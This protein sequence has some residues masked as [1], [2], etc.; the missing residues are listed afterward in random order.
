MMRMRRRRRRSAHNIAEQIFDVNHVQ[1]V[2]ETV[3]SITLYNSLFLFF[4]FSVLLLLCVVSF[5]KSRHPQSVHH[6][7]F[8]IYLINKTGD[9]HN[10][11]DSRNSCLS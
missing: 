2:P 4:F 9:F 5:T 11:D 3:C 10:V 8:H 1:N 7:H 6:T